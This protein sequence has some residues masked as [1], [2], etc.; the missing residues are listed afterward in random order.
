MCRP[1]K[2]L[3]GS[4]WKVLNLWWF[5]NIFKRSFIYTLKKLYGSYKGN[6]SITLPTNVC[7]VKAMA[8]PVVVYGYERWTIKTA[9]C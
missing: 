6:F 9:E 3:K 7:I 4:H 1:R 5:I 8:F 2:G